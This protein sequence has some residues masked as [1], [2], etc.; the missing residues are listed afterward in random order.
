MKLTIDNS[1]CNISPLNSKQLS[2]L[3]ELLHYTVNPQAA[4][5]S[6]GYGPTKRYLIDPKGNFPSGLL[7]LV[8]QWAKDY[9]IKLT[10]ND[11]RI[12]PTP[13]SGMFF[14]RLK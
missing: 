3:K 14:L 5:F 4:F 9:N 6:G 12:V 2:E 1:I 8:E 11:K 13:K 10:I 7:Y